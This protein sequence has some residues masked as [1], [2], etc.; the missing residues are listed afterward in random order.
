[1]VSNDLNKNLSSALE[2]LTR[3]VVFW[4]EDET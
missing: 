1:M 3:G 4:L 2:K